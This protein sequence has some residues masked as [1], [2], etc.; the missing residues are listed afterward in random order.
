NAPTTSEAS[1]GALLT[2]LTTSLGKP[3]SA[4]AATMSAWVLGQRSEALRITVLPQARGVAIARQPRITGA[5]HGAIPSTTPTGSLSA[6]DSRPGLSEGI[7]S[8]AI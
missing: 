8:P 5:F 6:S 2:R 1:S 7:I 3:A 4:N